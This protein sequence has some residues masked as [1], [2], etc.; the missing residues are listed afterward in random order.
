MDKTDENQKVKLIRVG[1][2]LNITNSAIIPSSSNNRKNIFSSHNNEINED[3]GIKRKMTDFIYKRESFFINKKMDNN[4]FIWKRKSDFSKTIH[5]NKRKLILFN[6]GEDK[7]NS[8]IEKE[9]SKKYVNLKM[10][11]NTKTTISNDIFNNKD[12]KIFNN[13]YYIKTSNELKNELNHYSINATS[14][15]PQITTE[16]TKSTNNPFLLKE[17]KSLRNS[18]LI[19]TKLQKKINKSKLL[20]ENNSEYNLEH[21]IKNN[22]EEIMKLRQKYPFVLNP[23]P[24]KTKN[25]FDLPKSVKKTNKKYFDIVK[26][27]NDKIFTQYFSVIAKEKFSK[28]FQNI[29]NIFDYRNNSKHSNKNANI[30]RKMFDFDK[31]EKKDSLINEKIVSGYKLLKEIN[32]RENINF[33]FKTKLSK[34]TLHY[35]FKK[36][37][38]FLCSKINNIS[39]FMNEILENYRKPKYSYY[40]P[41]SQELFF[42]IKTHNMQ[43]SNN[44]LDNYKYIVLDFDY[45]GMTALHWAA[46]NDFYQIIPKLFEYGSHMDDINYMGDTPLLISIKHNFMTSTIFLLMYLASPFIKNKDGKNAIYYSRKDFKLNKIFNKISLLHYTSIL[47]KSNNKMEFIQKGFCEYIID[48]YKND[49]E[50]DAYNVIN[51]KLEFFKRKNKIV[52]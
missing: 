50:I 14:V 45:F 12:N 23:N 16:S 38:I 22:Y 48:E 51:E 2:I 46:K 15:K 44:I 21:K 19:K 27:E 47:K 41:H 9:N 33:K 39:I 52:K 43:L 24:I 26:N 11:L 20:S 4:F 37:F 18:K 30:I 49:L 36:Y 13:L 35:K 28:K 6:M 42:A 32:N 10:S 1:K 17:K 29:G 5:N 40:Y 25:F 3:S 8:H 31:E 7:R 34:K